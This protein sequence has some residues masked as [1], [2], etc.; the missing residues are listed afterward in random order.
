[1]RLDETLTRVAGP[2]LDPAIPYQY[3]GTIKPAPLDTT[4]V[5]DNFDDGTPPSWIRGA[6]SGTINL[7]QTNGQ[8]TIRGNWPGIHTDTTAWASP[9]RAWAVNQGRS[10]EARVDLVSLKGDAASAMLAIYHD[11]GVGY[12]MSKGTNYICVGK[13][14]SGQTFLSADKLTTMNTNEVLV[15]ALTTAGQNVILTARVLD[16]SNGGAV[17]YEGSFPGHPGLRPNPELKPGVRDHGHGL[18]RPRG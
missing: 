3:T 17:L 15:L 14:N 10:L 13:Q 2:N 1:L 6:G 9:E 8:L 5:I 12:W 4:V 11:W 18:R 7:I 16:K